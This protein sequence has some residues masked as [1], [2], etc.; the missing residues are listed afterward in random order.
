MNTNQ[1]TLLLLLVVALTF[2]IIFKFGAKDKEGFQNTYDFTDINI[3]G[4]EGPVGPKGDTGP[5]GDRGPSCKNIISYVE[6]R[7]HLSLGDLSENNADK[8]FQLELKGQPIESANT[9]FAKL[10]ITDYERSYPIMVG[11]SPTDS[12]FHLQHDGEKVNMTLKGDMELKG[13]LNISEG[14]TTIDSNQ[15]FYDLAPVGLIAAFGGP[16][17][18]YSWT[19]CDG[20]TRD[21]F[22]TPDLRGKFIRGAASME[23]NGETNESEFDEEFRFKNGDIKLKTENL[24]EHK[25]EVNMYNSEDRT[26]QA[27]ILSNLI[28]QTENG[29][30]HRHELDHN[31]FGSL[32]N[33]GSYTSGDG[34]NLRLLLAKTSGPGNRTIRTKTAGEH[35]HGMSSSAQVRSISKDSEN[36]GEGRPINVLPP[37]YSLVYI[38]KYK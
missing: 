35:N 26:Q 17:I 20:S 28:R 13:E 27:N 3:K 1:K 36:T 4:D 6:K 16:S 10:K 9:D 31:Q 15:L 2:V 29:G 37:Y 11:N 23:Q 12:I 24:P 32:P 8:T 25:H 14:S 22:K 34:N 19:L 21:G 38:I 33:V 30:N 18:P 5:K 7:G